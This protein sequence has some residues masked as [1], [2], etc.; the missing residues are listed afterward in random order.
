[1]VQTLVITGAVKN[2]QYYPLW[3]Y[4]P[5]WSQEQSRIYSTARY[6]GTDTGDHR[7]SQGYTVL[8]FMMIETPV[9][10]GALKNIQYY[11]VWW[12]RPWWSQEQ[13]RIYNTTLYDRTDP[14]DHRSSQEYTILP[15][16]MVQILV[17]LM[18][19]YYYMYRLRLT[20][21]N[22]FL[23]LILVHPGNTIKVVWK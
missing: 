8:P 22:I 21:V 13:S 4:R 19:L 5:W 16:M 18:R 14:G 17:I 23:S 1:M 12:Y 6:D 20:G 2:I 11:L 9:I 15:C 3:W 10:T 7:S